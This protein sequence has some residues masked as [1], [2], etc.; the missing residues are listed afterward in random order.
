[1]ETYRKAP[2]K[3]SNNS[4]RLA[5]QSQY[6]TLLKGMKQGTPSSNLKINIST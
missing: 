6:C 3:V 4:F 2:G 1:M 5:F